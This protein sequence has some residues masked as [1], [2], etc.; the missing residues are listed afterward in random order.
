M[1]DLPIDD[2]NTLYNETHK[3]FEQIRQET[4]SLIMGDEQI[5]AEKAREYMQK[6]YV[7]YATISSSA[8]SEDTK[9]EVSKWPALVQQVA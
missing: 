6:A 5:S 8:K 2:F 3:R 9:V 7:T 1:Q 4:Y